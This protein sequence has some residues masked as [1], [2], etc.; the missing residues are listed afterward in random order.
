MHDVCLAEQKSLLSM[1][2][3]S[4]DRFPDYNAMVRSDKIKSC[5]WPGFSDLVVVDHVVTL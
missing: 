2:A 3:R 1:C 5:T 4:I